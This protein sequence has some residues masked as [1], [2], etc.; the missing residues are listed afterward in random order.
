MMIKIYWFFRIAAYA[1]CLGGVIWFL[2]HQTDATG[3]QEG[4][5]AVY[6]GF[7]A[8]FI[9]YAIR[10]FLRFGGH[11]RKRPSGGGEDGGR[12]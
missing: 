5:Y 8:F 11:P 6:A 10:F 2:A 1:A 12:E 3:G 4:L 7:V 9:S